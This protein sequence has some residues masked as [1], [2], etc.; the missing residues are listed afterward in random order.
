MSLEIIKFLE[1]E[2]FL[3]FCILF[4]ISLSCVIKFD[5][6]W[7]FFSCVLIIFVV[8]CECFYWFYDYVFLKDDFIFFVLWYNW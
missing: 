3:S 7:L 5:I 2:L 4:I 6:V 8:V 1:K